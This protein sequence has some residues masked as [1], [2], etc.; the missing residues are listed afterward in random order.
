MRGET[1]HFDSDAGEESEEAH[2]PVQRGVH[3]ALLHG[4]LLEHR[5]PVH[6]NRGQRPLGSGGTRVAGKHA[7]AQH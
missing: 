7:A 5:L 1:H 4:V 2:V 6:W 3:A